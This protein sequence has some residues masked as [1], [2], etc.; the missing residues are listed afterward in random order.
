VYYY[1]KLNNLN[2]P[3]VLFYFNKRLEVE[4]PADSGD[5]LCNVASNADY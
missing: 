2:V 3:P 4:I 1:T 5:D